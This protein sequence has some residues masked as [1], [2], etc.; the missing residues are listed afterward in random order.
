MSVA[1][2]TTRSE[3]LM[4]RAHRLFPGGVSSPVRA[5]RAVG[6]T[7]RVIER[8]AGARVWDVDGNELLDYVGSWG[9]MILGHAHPA[10]IEAVTE[11]ARRGTSYG[12]PN[13]HEVELGELI[14]RRHAVDR[15][16]AV[17]QLGHRGGDE[18]HPPGA[19][20][21][22][23]RRHREDGRRLPRPRRC[24]ARRAWI[25][26]H[27]HAGQRGRHRCGGTRHARRALQRPRGSR[28]PARLD[29]RRCRHR[30]AGGRE[31]GRR[32]AGAGLPRGPP[33][34]RP[35]TTARC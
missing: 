12:A 31:H 19:R 35:P 20:G 16:A 24:A 23:P 2:G 28:T 8:A 27:R 4:A 25:G 30:R 29:A 13:P 7:P 15:A 21:D 34:P 14:T 9:P 1:L 22:G 26:R 17:R 3:E 32:A 33:R 10:V 6:G 18:R 11:A 5:F